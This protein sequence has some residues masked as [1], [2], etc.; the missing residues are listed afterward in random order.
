[1]STRELMVAIG[2][3][4]LWLVVLCLAAPPLLTFFMTRF[5]EREDANQFP[6]RYLYSLVV[7]GVVIPGVFSVVTTGYTFLFTAENLLD[8]DIFLVF[9]PIVTMVLTVQ[10]MK[11]NHVNIDKLP[12]FGRLMGLI[13]LMGAASVLAIIAKKTDIRIWFIGSV[14]SLFWFVAVIV[15]AGS[16]GYTKL[17]GGSDEEPSED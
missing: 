2:N 3:Q 1:M 12:G 8:F 5:H 9:G 13:L 15:V 6:W 17:F 7:F 4:P 11:S 16:I 10:V 14:E